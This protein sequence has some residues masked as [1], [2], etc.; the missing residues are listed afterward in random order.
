MKFK[1]AKQVLQHAID[2][3]STI[4]IPKLKKLLQALN[5]GL[6]ST[7]SNEVKYLKNEV[8]NLHKQLRK[9]QKEKEVK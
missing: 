2:H 8:K 5:I 9:L 3:Q 4:S 7:E 6:E 1:Q